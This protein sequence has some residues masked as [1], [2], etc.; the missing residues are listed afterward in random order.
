MSIQLLEYTIQAKS[1]QPPKYFKV[2]FPLTVIGSLIAGYFINDFYSNN[3]IKTLRE[4]ND[5]L[6]TIN[7]Q[8]QDKIVQLET[9]VTLLKTEQKV[10][11]QAIAEV[12]ND[13]KGLIDD[14]NFLKSEI[15]FYE[16][17]LSPNEE[18]KGLR[19]F[20]AAATQNNSDSFSLKVVLVQKIERAKE[21][22]GRFEIVLTGQ[23]NDKP[24]NLTISNSEE[25]NYAFKYFYNISLGFSIPEGFKAEQLVVK[26][27][28]KNKKAKTIEYK[29][30]WHSI[31]N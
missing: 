21:I 16:R 20:E 5:V 18:N 11:Q 19:V 28:P 12:Q 1:K 25:A 26:L 27:Y 29:V 7:T 14:I 31:I 17:L 3:T 4:R 24:K 2:L 15:D 22:S 9:S 13:Y 10:R 8:N 30:N 6:E 23:Q